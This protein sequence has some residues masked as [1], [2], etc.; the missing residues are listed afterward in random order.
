MAGHK[1]PKFGKQPGD[2]DKSHKERVKEELDNVSKQRQET[3]DRQ[4][5]ERPAHDPIEGETDEA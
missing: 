1:A 2:D 3:R 4:R 5:D